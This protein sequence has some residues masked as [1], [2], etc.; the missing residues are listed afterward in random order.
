MLCEIVYINTVPDKDAT[1]YIPLIFKEDKFIFF[2]ELFCRAVWLLA[3]TRREMKAKVEEDHQK[4]N[5][6]KTVITILI[7]FLNKGSSSFKGTNNFGTKFSAEE[8]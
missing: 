1:L 2:E 7:F 6:V 4:V 5:L 3:K 8:I